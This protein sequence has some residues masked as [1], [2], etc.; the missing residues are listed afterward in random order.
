MPIVNQHYVKKINEYIRIKI[1]KND[2]IPGDIFNINEYVDFNTTIDPNLVFYCKTRKP[3]IIFNI[4]DK[5]SNKYFDLSKYIKNPD[6]WIRSNLQY[7]IARPIMNFGSS[8]F[9]GTAMQLIFSMLDLYKFIKNMPKYYNLNV[10]KDKAQAYDYIRNLLIL[11]KT[12]SN[13]YGPPITN[14]DFPYYPFI[15][16]QFNVKQKPDPNKPL[17]NE[18]GDIDE[19]Y[20]LFVSD[21]LK[22]PRKLFTTTVINHKYHVINTN[23][24]LSNEEERLTMYIIRND[25]IKPNNED[26]LKNKNTLED[27]L[28]DQYANVELKSG[29][30]S[31]ESHG[32]RNAYYDFTEIKFIPDF[33]YIHL[34]II[35]SPHRTKYELNLKIN[36]TL[37]FTH[38]NDDGNKSTE[39]YVLKGIVFHQG[40]SIET[41]HY[42]ALILS[43]LNKSASEFEYQYYND[44][45]IP[46][47]ITFPLNSK[48][49][50][51]DKLPDY[52]INTPYILVYMVIQ[53]I[54]PI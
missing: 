4:I 28:Y 8:C 19:F 31:H 12:K 27:C 32:N 7:S 43:E 42:T 18:E 51:L 11:M 1:S 26:P 25:I 33:W 10:P 6:I 16:K 46:T 23:I 15:E 50:P 2:P 29:S 53:R 40:N 24:D 54:H 13:K 37:V 41:G 47:K 44:G 49:I 39:T 21:I 48:F 20:I 36:T 52:K 34:D 9:F 5:N 3:P 14:I 30:A 22:W 38:L 17:K 45:I 35:T